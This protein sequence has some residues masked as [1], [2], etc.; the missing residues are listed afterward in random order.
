[1]R[2]QKEIEAAVA[3]KIAD[4]KK[5]RKKAQRQFELVQKPKESLRKM[6]REASSIGSKAKK[7]CGCRSEERSKEEKKEWQ[8]KPQ[9]VSRGVG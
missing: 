9:L 3:K 1:M 5:A 2:L 8:R 7:D 6:T 4:E